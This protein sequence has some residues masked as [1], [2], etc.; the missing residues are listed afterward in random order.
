MRT[1]QYVLYGGAAGGGKSYIL[2]WA[3]ILIAMSLAAAKIR[4]ARLGLFC[5]TYPELRLRHFAAFENMPSFLG[6]WI[7][8]DTEFVLSPQYGSHKISLLN[9]DQPEKYKS[10]EFA[11]IA[12]DELTEVQNAE[13]LHTLFSR[14]RWAGVPKPPFLAASN[15]DG[16]LH[17]KVKRLWVAGDFSHPDDCRLDPAAFKFIK[18]LPTDNPHL[19]KEYI[20]GTLEG[21]PEHMRKAW[22]EGSWDLFEGARF[23]IVPSVHVVKPFALDP[24]RFVFYRSIDYGFNNPYACTWFAVDYHGSRPDVFLF[25]EDVASSLHS[26]AQAQ[27]VIEKTCELID[28]T[29]LDTACWKL[30]D[31][32][33]SIADKFAQEGVTCQQVMKDRATGWAYLEDL[34]AFKSDNGIVT[35]PPRLQ[36]FETCPVAIRQMTDAMW[37]P[38]KPGDILHPEGFRDDVL[39]T[40]RYFALTHFSGVQK[41]KEYDTASIEYLNAL[42]ASQFKKKRTNRYGS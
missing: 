6:K 41:P 36:V 38:R 34:L 24:A 15:P 25:R 42:A 18:A 20:A 26:R 31:D 27:R 32:G 3:L 23:D 11:A 7:K 14:L 16:P 21:L 2:R 8:S 39:D 22:L 28:L 37:D 5:N 1:H 19:S 35:E 33:L 12:V 30:E 4:G 10:A 13:T 9:L 40:I 29:Y 17:S